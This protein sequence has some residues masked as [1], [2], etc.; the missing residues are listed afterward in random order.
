MKD[1][2]ALPAGGYVLKGFESKLAERIRRPE[3]ALREG[4]QRK[5]ALID[6]PG[7]PRVYLKTF[8][9]DSGV[10]GTLVRRGA[11]RARREFRNLIRAAECGVPAPRALALVESRES[12]AVWTEELDGMG[13][14]RS[15]FAARPDFETR[16]TVLAALGP[17]LK[18]IHDRGFI[19]ADLH[20]GNLLVDPSGP[21]FAVVDLASVS[22]LGKPLTRAQRIESLALLLT[23]FQIDL[24]MADYVRVLRSYGEESRASWEAISR[25]LIDMRARFV[26]NRARKAEG[27][28]SAFTRRKIGRWDVVQGPDADAERLLAGLDWKTIHEWTP[29]ERG[30]SARFFEDTSEARRWWLRSWKLKYNLVPAPVG[31]LWAR[32]SR[33]SVIMARFPNPS[34]IPR[35][36]ESLR[37]LGLFLRRMHDF[38][39]T[40]RGLTLSDV[41]SAPGASYRIALTDPSRAECVVPVTAA[42][43]AREFASLCASFSE[44]ERHRVFQGY[45][46]WSRSIWRAEKSFGIR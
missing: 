37:D 9:N 31:V 2:V 35:D 46:G 14:L 8:Y 10:L 12:C 38:G 13:T 28:G 36:S 21:R 11:Y 17:F 42:M 34:P 16:R 30:L 29:L 25:R 20:A 26:E 32:R 1:Y 39:V 27:S 4:R 33:G 23:S 43:R 44:Q 22:F 7:G 18:S 5:L 40:V 19:H 15:L 6:L 45:A 24:H 3:T 41:V